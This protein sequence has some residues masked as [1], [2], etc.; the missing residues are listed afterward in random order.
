MTVYVDNSRLP[1]RGQSWC[2]LVADSVAELH[3][4]A[5]RLGLKREWFQ[6]KTRYPHYDVTVNVRRRALELGAI[7]GDKRAIIT[8]AKQMYREIAAMRAGGGVMPILEA[9]S[10]LSEK[11]DATSPKSA[12]AVVQPSLF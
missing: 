4:F 3:A 6:D 5:E 10:L 2:H 12:S 9:S 11:C 7:D 1:W 8:C